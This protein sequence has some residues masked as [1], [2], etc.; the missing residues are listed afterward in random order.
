MCFSENSLNTKQTN[1]MA[2]ETI[3]TLMN[4]GYWYYSLEGGYPS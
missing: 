4:N 3:F 2:N 1:K